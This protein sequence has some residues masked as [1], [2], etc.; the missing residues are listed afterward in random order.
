MVSDFTYYLGLGTLMGGL[1]AINLKG[2]MSTNSTGLAVGYALLIL[3]CFGCTGSFVTTAWH[4]RKGET[5]G[6]QAHST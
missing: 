4:K 2:L 6:R 1:G 5:H 3:F